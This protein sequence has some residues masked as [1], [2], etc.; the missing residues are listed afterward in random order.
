MLHSELENFMKNAN[1][2]EKKIIQAYVNRSV[3]FHALIT[4]SM[5]LVCLAFIVE[6]IVLSQSFP[7]DVSYP[8]SIDQKFVHA[9]LYV[10]QVVTLFFIAS[11]LTVD[12][13]VAT[14][15][16]FTGARFEIL[17]YNFERVTDEK[18]LNNCIKKHQY[19]LWYYGDNYTTEY[20]E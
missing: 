19:L 5:W 17:G 2:L 8:F 20:Y 16:W 9:A 4:T 7:T 12:F 15:L 18:Q 1:P 11:A 3:I 13:Q 6:P 10:Q 14:L